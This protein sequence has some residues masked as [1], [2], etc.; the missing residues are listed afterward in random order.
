MVLAQTWAA[1]AGAFGS[2]PAHLPQNQSQSQ[3]R[4]AVLAEGAAPSGPAA[5]AA[6][7]AGTGQMRT[8]DLSP[9]ETEAPG[10]VG[11]APGVGGLTPGVVAL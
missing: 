8:G 1:G 3:N 2:P 11:P 9:M 4:T 7:P 6:A 10:D 5:V